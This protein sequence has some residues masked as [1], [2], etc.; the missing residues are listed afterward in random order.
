MGTKQN[1][2]NFQLRL[3]DPDGLATLRG[4]RE[5][6][7]PPAWNTSARNLVCVFPESQ[8]DE[9]RSSPHLILDCKDATLNFLRSFVGALDPSEQFRPYTQGVFLPSG[10]AAIVLPVWDGDRV[11]V[12]AI[13]A[14]LEGYS[15]LACSNYASF[16]G[17]RLAE[18]AENRKTAKSLL[19]ADRR[20]ADEASHY[21]RLLLNLYRN[22]CI[23]DVQGGVYI[24]GGKIRSERNLQRS[25]LPE[26]YGLIVFDLG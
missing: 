4:P 1:D 10:D 15:R 2:D 8:F 19:G 9:L 6:K 18:R 7:E 24:I 14:G 22:T 5:P 25:S 21:N 17:G 12:A 16:L 23:L 3:Y 13:L 26:S 11:Y 20:G